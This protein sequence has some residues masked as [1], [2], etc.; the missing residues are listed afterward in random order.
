MEIIDMSKRKNIHGHRRVKRAPFKELF[1]IDKTLSSAASKAGESDKP[2]DYSE[3]L[4]GIGTSLREGAESVGSGVSKGIESAG[5]SLASGITG[6]AKEDQTGYWD[7]N[8]KKSS[9]RM[10]YNKHG[11]PFKG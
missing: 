6:K 1:I 10:K 9:F 8:K 3:S 2:A 4:G 5:E 7:P 11:F